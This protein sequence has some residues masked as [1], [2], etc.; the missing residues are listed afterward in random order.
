MPKPIDLEAFLD[1]TF[2][3]IDTFSMLS[4]I[5]DFI[6]FSENNIDWQKRREIRHTEI[7]CANE[8]FDTPH[9]K[10]KFHE[11]MID[12]VHYRFEVSLSQRIRYATLISLITTIEWVLSSLK[13]RSNIKIP[14]KTN[15]TS[16]AVHLLI[17][18]DQSAS[19]GLSSKIQII[20]TLVQVRN[21]IVHAAGLLASY[22]HSSDL[23]Q[24]LSTYNGIRISDINRLGDA[25]EIEKNH[26]QR[27]VEDVKGWLP[28]LENDMQAKGLL[29]R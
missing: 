22:K 3:S 21:C 16:D 26:L 29:R 5:K 4:D 18:F 20:E 12:A 7:A 9:E 19:A 28:S 17:Q 27:V 14:K 2:F 25:I 23:Q 11:Q 6:D 1:K 10:A 15:R 24:R 13:K 8:H